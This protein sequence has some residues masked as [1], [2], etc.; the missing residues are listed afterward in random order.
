MFTASSDNP[1]EV[2]TVMDLIPVALTGH[3]SSLYLLISTLLSD[4]RTKTNPFDLQFHN[5]RLMRKVIML[6]QGK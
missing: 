2:T 4:Y 3:C 5:S 1:D 6:K